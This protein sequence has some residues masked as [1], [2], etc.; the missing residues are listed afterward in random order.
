[1]AADDL[2]VIPLEA[3]VAAV[4]RRELVPATRPERRCRCHLAPLLEARDGSLRCATSRQIVTAWH[5]VAA[6]EVVAS[7]SVL[8]PLGP[9][10]PTDARAVEVP[11]DAARGARRR[12][13]V[14]AR[15]RAKRGR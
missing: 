14:A 9:P 12:L 13:A 10:L 2:E 15:R 7:S 8:A 1:M 4:T 6:G 5:V 3:V 11:D